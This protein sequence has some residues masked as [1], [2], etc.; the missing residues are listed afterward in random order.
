MTPLEALAIIDQVCASVPLNR[1]DQSQVMQALQAL[2]EI[3]QPEET[4]EKDAKK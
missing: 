4:G 1:A 3:A 2:A